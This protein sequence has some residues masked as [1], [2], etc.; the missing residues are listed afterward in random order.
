MMTVFTELHWFNFPDREPRVFNTSLRKIMLS[1]GYDICKFGKPT[2]L[3]KH[4]GHIPNLDDIAHSPATIEFLNKC[5]VDFYLGE[6]LSVGTPVQ[7][8]RYDNVVNCS[9]IDLRTPELDSIRNYVLRN[10]LTNVTVYVGDYN[11]EK[12]T[13]YYSPYMKLVLKDIF[14]YSTTLMEPTEPG[15][16]T[17]ITFKFVNLNGRYTEYRHIIALFLKDKPAI[18]SWFHDKDLPVKTDWYDL[19]T[20]NS[21]ITET[22]NGELGIRIVD[23]P[24]ST[25]SQF[26]GKLEEVYATCFCD[27]VSESRFT[28]PLGNIS[29]KTTRSMLYK[30]PFIL[31]ASYKTLEYLKTLRFKTFSD[32]WDESY[33][34]CENHE[35]RIKKILALIEHINSKSIDELK[36]MLY[37]M[38][39]ILEHNFEN[40]NKISSFGKRNG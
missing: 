11:I 10:N 1:V 21:S 38:E 40:L 13:A 8:A 32:F 26:S 31:A 2:Y 28:N 20:W 36:S 17:N 30:K 15:L 22:L 34:E 12:Y 33:D 19:T 35:D 39:P 14:L 27:I 25:F 3:Y 16:R 6:P 4:S 7:D 24:Y 29:E 37:R 9:D 5:G 23:N 18:V